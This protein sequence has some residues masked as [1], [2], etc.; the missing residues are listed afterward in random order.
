[1]A[2]WHY[3]NEKGEK[4]TVTGGQLKG[5][6]KA[7]MITPETVIET[8]DG[9]TAP[10]GKVKGLTF[11]E[12]KQS[13]TVQPVPTVVPIP[14]TVPATP[15]VTPPPIKKVNAY[16]MQSVLAIGLIM[17]LVFGIIAIIFAAISGANLFFLCLLC[18]I[19]SLAMGAWAAGVIRKREFLEYSN[20]YFE[21][22]RDG[23]NETTYERVLSYL[24]SSVNSQQLNSA[25]TLPERIRCHNE[26]LLAQFR[27]VKQQITQ[28]LVN[29]VAK[30]NPFGTTAVPA[31][32]LRYNEVLVVR[33]NAIVDHLQKVNSLVLR[34]ELLGVGR[35]L[36]EL[37]A[38]LLTNFPSLEW[39][40]QRI[41]NDQMLVSST[42]NSGG[43][44]IAS[45]IE[46]LDELCK[47]G[48]ISQEEFERGKALFLGSSP[49]IADKTLG[50]LDSLHRLKTNGALSESEYN[51]KKWELLG[52]KNLNPK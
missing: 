1:M 48:V 15:Q 52:G 45:Q 22:K 21:F 27:N 14:L 50:I 5:L 34:K 20:L 51:V 37:N 43:I 44:S 49:D 35:V 30:P 18:A 10:A 13:E 8:E 28:Q 36:I 41:T 39:N 29:N 25:I 46:T 6:A 31:K 42:A 4:I 3:Y 2:N 24:N 33:Y 40:E 12:T 7:G 9:K 11:V 17:S 19:A 26:I 38:N 16:I 32:I 23:L 47:N